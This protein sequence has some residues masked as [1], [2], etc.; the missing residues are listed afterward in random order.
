MKK[1][2]EERNDDGRRRGT[3][4]EP[5]SYESELIDNCVV[6]PE[7]GADC[8]TL[9]QQHASH[10]YGRQRRRQLLSVSEDARYQRFLESVHLVHTHNQR[11]DIHHT[12]G[13]NQFSDLNEKELPLAS[14]KSAT[15]TASSNNEDVWKAAGFD[16]E[17][18]L[19][20]LSSDGGDD[21]T[22]LEFAA[23]HDRS[24]NRRQ[25]RNHH[26]GHH[27]RHHHHNHKKNHDKIKVY[28]NPNDDN[29]WSTLD[30]TVA[31]A[32]GHQVHIV[33]TEME[34]NHYRYDDDDDGAMTS[35][36]RMVTDD[37]NVIDNFDTNLN[38][39]SEEN[40]DGVSIVHDA[41]D[42]GS[43]GSC[44]AFAATGT[45]EASASRRVANEAYKKHLT[46]NN[47]EQAEVVAQQAEEHAIRLANLSVQELI[48]CDN[49]IDQ[50][51]TGGNPL[52]AFYF[53]HRYGLTSTHDYPYTGDQNLCHVHRVADPIATSQSWGILTMDHEDNME[54]VL[55]WIG[56]IAVGVNGS[57]PTFLAYKRGIYDN[58]HGC[59]QQANHAMLIVGY[60]QEEVMGAD[61][62]TIVVRYWI[63]RNSWGSQWGE[64]GYV[65]IKRGSGAKG[66][67]GVCGIAKNPS[68][69]LG[70][71]LL[72]KSGIHS[73]TNTASTGG[74]LDD[75]S[76][77]SQ[78]QRLE[79]S[80]LTNY[81]DAIGLGDLQTCHRIEGLLQLYPALT[82]GIISVFAVI[83]F[84]VWPLTG[85]CRARSRRR[86]IRRRLQLEHSESE[87]LLAEAAEG[88]LS[89]GSN[90]DNNN[91]DA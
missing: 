70:G 20:Q 13:L 8:E 44:W 47:A 42:Q 50:G 23:L 59:G 3:E 51:C 75:R 17:V 54:T 72:P 10:Y 82:Y 40:P 66:E 58:A 2:E 77:S 6:A 18:D 85:D 12:I 19:I 27:G 1:E 30:S 61:G 11:A 80:L 24:S 55:R 65:R 35:D 84:V 91:N 79:E 57:D 4:E 5:F 29:K 31:A 46:G 53:I 7:G 48:D 83:I 25:L 41:S 22:I 86:E 64:N 89:Y 32:E 63:A 87:T 56:P 49:A 34:L 16:M 33:A 9:Y 88:A 62:T 36:N 37:D 52:L 39:A 43:C 73:A 38:W 15:T 74:A 68:V 76:V 67:A 45:L 14:T 78:A 21:D 26:G 71:V 28:V 69:S 90:G 81:C 60:G